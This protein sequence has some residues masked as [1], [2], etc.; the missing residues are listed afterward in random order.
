MKGMKKTLGVLACI[1]CDSLLWLTVCGGKADTNGL[2]TG[3]SPGGISAGMNADAGSGQG[4]KAE[5]AE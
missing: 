2:Q 1:C 3:E 5:A 4:D